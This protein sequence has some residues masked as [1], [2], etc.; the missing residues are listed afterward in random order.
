MI[1]E[2]KVKRRLLINN[3]IAAIMGIIIY[4][5]ICYNYGWKL[6]VLLYLFNFFINFNQNN[7]IDSKIIDY[8]EILNDEAEGENNE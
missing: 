5:L 7:L 4:T 6:A 1:N 8:S 2:K 3:V